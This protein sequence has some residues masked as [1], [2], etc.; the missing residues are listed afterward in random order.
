MYPSAVNLELRVVTIGFPDGASPTTIPG[1]H[2]V[3][4]PLNC[5]SNTAAPLATAVDCCPQK[6]DVKKGCVG[7]LIKDVSV[8]ESILTSLLIATTKAMKMIGM[9]TS[10]MLPQKPLFHKIQFF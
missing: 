4:V 10:M 9:M 2:P 6:F 3:F 7:L 1:L 5:L 8:Y